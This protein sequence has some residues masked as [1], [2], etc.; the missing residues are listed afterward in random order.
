MGKIKVNLGEN[1]HYIY[2][3]YPLEEIGK[4]IKNSKFGKKFV[5]LSDNNVF[6]I[7]GEKVKKSIEKENRIVKK[8]VIPP[9]EKQK[10]LN[11]CLKIIE[12]LLKFEINR[13]ETLINLGGG[14]INDIG[15]FVASIYMRG[16]NIFQFLRHYFLKWM[17]LLVEKQGLI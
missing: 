4:K 17:L 1:T 3:D 13:D 8:I 15:G 12:N 11:R 14:V 9:G 10:N 2:I 5:I 16:I 6:P 7:Y